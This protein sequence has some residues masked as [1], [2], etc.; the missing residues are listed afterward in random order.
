MAYGRNNIILDTRRAGREGSFQHANSRHATSIQ[1]TVGQRQ[2]DVSLQ[3]K[4]KPRS[5]SV[6]AN[7]SASEFPVDSVSL[8]LILAIVLALLWRHIKHAES[9]SEGQ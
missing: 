5:A 2:M 3:V 7:S 8:N 4:A 6:L 9:V 1:Y